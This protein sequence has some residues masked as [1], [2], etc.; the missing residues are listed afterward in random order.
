MRDSGRD[1]P[2]DFNS[3]LPLTRGP[4]LALSSGGEDGAFG[5]GLLNGLSASGKQP[6]YS[7]LTGVSTGALIAPFAFG[8]SRYNDALRNAFT[9]ITSAN[10]YE[11]GATPESFVDTWPLKDFI[12]KEITPALM[13]DKCR[14]HKRRSAGEGGRPQ[15][16]EENV[17]RGIP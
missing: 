4:W 11:V 9:T 8:G 5:A 12:G 14:H 1:S 13:H 17:A 2:A 15:G 3:A 6:A 10:V 7:V 16:T